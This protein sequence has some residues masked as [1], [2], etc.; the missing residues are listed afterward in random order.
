MTQG[1]VTRLAGVE[2]M[3]HLQ[4]RQSEPNLNQNNMAARAHKSGQLFRRL[5][6][7]NVQQSK[8]NRAYS[9]IANER[10]PDG[11]PHIHCQQR[12]FA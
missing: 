7:R 4:T 8:E 3:L 11:I 1:G 5:Y 6:L 2:F 12:Y 10:R 9:G